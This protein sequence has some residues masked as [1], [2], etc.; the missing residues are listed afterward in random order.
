MKYELKI[1]TQVER[2]LKAYSKAGDLKIIDKIKR[3]FKELSEH[4]EEGIGR[5]ERLKHG[6]TGYWSREVD[7][8]NRIVYEI[9][10]NNKIVI[11]TT[12]KS[13]YSDK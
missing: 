6:L 8:K 4:P 5:P 3:I 11:V 9:D 2:D 7:P 13:H 1:T 12:V 10:E